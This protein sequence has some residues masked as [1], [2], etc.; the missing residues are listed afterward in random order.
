MMVTRWESP[1]PLQ[2][3]VESVTASTPPEASSRRQGGMKGE[4]ESAT[5][6]DVWHEGH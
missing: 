1:T 5:H 2:S 3:G 6:D 4:K